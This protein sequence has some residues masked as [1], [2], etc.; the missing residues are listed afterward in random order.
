MW[1]WVEINTRW[2]TLQK[3][4][5]HSDAKRGLSPS[6]RDIH[7]IFSF[8]SFSLFGQMWKCP[9]WNA[10]ELSPRLLFCTVYCFSPWC[11][12]PPLLLVVIYFRC[13]FVDVHRLFS[14]IHCRAVW[15]W[16]FVRYLDSRLTLG[17]F[18]SNFLFDH[19]S[20]KFK[21]G[22]QT[23]SWSK[24]QD[25]IS[26]LHIL[27]SFSMRMDSSFQEQPYYGSVCWPLVP[28]HPLPSWS[29]LRPSWFGRGVQGTVEAWSN[30]S[31]VVVALLRD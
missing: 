17:W 3:P 23:K 20:L 26:A 6:T 15:T 12:M 1:T 27:F 9:N 2:S 29:S 4:Q 30:S 14:C 28:S 16:W 22:W 21:R 5:L 18:I 10:G 24:Q 8:S 19:N 7:N 25:R 11:W 31:C 13:G